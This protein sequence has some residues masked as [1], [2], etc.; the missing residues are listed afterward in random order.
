MVEVGEVVVVA[1]ND[2]G[3]VLDRSRGIAVRRRTADSFSE[4]ECQE[5]DAS[6]EDQNDTEQPHFLTPRSLLFRCADT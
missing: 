1:M 2:N 3:G 4:A 5:T 6:H